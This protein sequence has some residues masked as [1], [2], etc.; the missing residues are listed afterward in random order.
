MLTCQ[1]VCRQSAMLFACRHPP[2]PRVGQCGQGCDGR[3]QKGSWGLPDYYTDRWQTVARHDSSPSGQDILCCTAVEA[4]G[5]CKV[6]NT[7]AFASMYNLCFWQVP[8]HCQTMLGYHAGCVHLEAML[9]CSYIFVC[10]MPWC[11]SPRVAP[12]RCC[13]TIKCLSSLGSP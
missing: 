9:L 11:L 1:R 7:K 6:H 10:L 2:T 8:Q 12:V 3:P 4:P 13:C 5:L